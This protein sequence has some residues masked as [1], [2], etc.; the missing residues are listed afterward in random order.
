V[1]A[2]PADSRTDWNAWIPSTRAGP[3]KLNVKDSGIS[4]PSACGSDVVALTR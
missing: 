3:Y 4:Q 1:L 2:C